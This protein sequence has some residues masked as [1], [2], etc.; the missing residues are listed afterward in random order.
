M[1]IVFKMTTIFRHVI[2]MILGGVAGAIIFGALGF[3]ILVSYGG[4]HGCFAL[5]DSI[6]APMKGYESCGLF[7]LWIG[8]IIGIIVGVFFG[9]LFCRKRKY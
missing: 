5:A 3:F 6:F 1:N 9:S 4:N 8:F 2:K 7:G